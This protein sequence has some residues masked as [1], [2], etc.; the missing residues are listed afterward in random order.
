[1]LSTDDATPTWRNTLSGLVKEISDNMVKEGE[2]RAPFQLW[3]FRRIAETILASLKVS[4][5]VRS[6]LLSHVELL[7]I[8]SKMT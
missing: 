6:H 1:V 5:D 4:E 7:R 3:D 2:A 8:L